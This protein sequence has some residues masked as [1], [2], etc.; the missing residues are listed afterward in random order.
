MRQFFITLCAIGYFGFAQ[1]QC[2]PNANA[3]T[4]IPMMADGYTLIKSFEI[5]D[6]NKEKEKVEYSYVFTKGTKYLINVCGNDGTADGVI[7]TVYD[8]YRNQVASSQVNGN[9]AQAIAVTCKATGIYYLTYTFQQTSAHCAGS[10]IGF[11][12]LS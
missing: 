4:C 11:K 8:K 1:A 7:I 12:R 2:D 10:N 3:R 5:D 6:N 9:A